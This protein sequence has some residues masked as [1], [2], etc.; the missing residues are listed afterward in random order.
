MIT[1][2]PLVCNCITAVLCNCI[3]IHG[4]SESSRTSVISSLGHRRGS[5]IVIHLANLS[6]PTFPNMASEKII[7]LEKMASE[8]SRKIAELGGSRQLQCGGDFTLESCS[9]SA[10][11]TSFMIISSAIVLMMTIPGLG[12]YYGGMVKVKNVLATVMQAFSIV[13]IIT[14]MYF[15]FGYSLA[16]GPPN[17]PAYGV[18]DNGHSSLFY[19]D[20][21]RF[22]L[23]GV[24]PV[25]Y[26]SLA[27]TIPENVYAFFQLTFAIITAALICGSFADRMKYGPMLIFMSL[28]HIGELSVP[29]TSLLTCHSGLLPHRPLHLAFGRLPLPNGEH[30]LRWRKRRAHLLWCG[31]PLLHHH[32]WQPKG[33]R[34]GAVRASQHLANLRRSLSPLGGMVR[35]QCR[36]RGICQRPRRPSHAQHSGGHLDG[37]HDL[38]VHRVGHQEE[39]LRH[40]HGVRCNRRTGRH[41]S[42]L[43][44]GGSDGRLL[45]R[46]SRRSLVLHGRSDQTLRRIR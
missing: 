45:H 29:V 46:L 32:H 38:D 42:R 39:A 13:C 27:S 7:A 44:L 14:A 36:I 4:S 12:L 16:F 3:E 10:G 23:W 6:N 35:I 5:T 30:G 34:Q 22:W 9:A 18:I 17:P 31:R 15:F 37:R 8:L 43:R 2:C 40:G 21:S 1:G 41:H 11:D 26:N 19:G 28:W 24:S 25:T 33:L 20:A